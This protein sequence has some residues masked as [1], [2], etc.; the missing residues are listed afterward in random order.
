MCDK[1]LSKKQLRGVIK[2]AIRQLKVKTPH[3]DTDGKYAVAYDLD[4]DGNKEYFVMLK[5]TGIGDNVFWGVFRVKSARFLG[6]IFAEHIF[7]RERVKGWA[8]LTASSHLSSS[9]SLVT[10]YAY[11]NGKYIQAAGGYEINANRND[12]PKFMERTSVL[13]LCERK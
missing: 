4:G 5:D 2:S 9:D 3:R 8:A 1:S 7:L 10:T 6:V 12:H 13:Y 11:R